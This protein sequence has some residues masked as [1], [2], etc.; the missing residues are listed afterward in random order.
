MCPSSWCGAALSLSLTCDPSL[1]HYSKHNYVKEKDDW[2]GA[3]LSLFPREWG[4]CPVMFQLCSRNLGKRG[5]QTFIAFLDIS[6]LIILPC[7]IAGGGVGY[8]WG[9]LHKLFS[10]ESKVKYLSDMA[11]WTDSMYC[12][13]LLMYNLYYLHFLIQRMLE[14][15]LKL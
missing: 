6:Q 8:S 4:E 10:G 13:P 7:P 14:G 11:H 1:P 15:I 5:A 9:S 2:G 3:N 12:C